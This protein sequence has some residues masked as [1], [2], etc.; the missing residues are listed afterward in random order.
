M[1]IINLVIPPTPTH[2]GAS[3]R[4]AACMRVLDRMYPFGMHIGKKIFIYTNK[5]WMQ[6]QARFISQ[7]FNHWIK[8]KIGPYSHTPKSTLHPCSIKTTIQ[9]GA[10]IPI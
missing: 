9:N 6:S 5:I 2:A 4:G 1:D 10:Y 7:I 3:V 8:N